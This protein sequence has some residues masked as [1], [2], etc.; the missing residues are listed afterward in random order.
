MSHDIDP[1]NK[2][3]FPSYVDHGSS[4][5][6][7]RSPFNDKGKGKERRRN[8]DDDSWVSTPDSIS[9]MES[10]D[11]FLEKLQEQHEQRKRE[12]EEADRVQ[13]IE[14]EEELR[15]ELE[16]TDR[17]AAE[18]ADRLAAEEAARLAEEEAIPRL[19]DCMACAGRLIS[20]FPV[21]ISP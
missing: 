14:L 1:A 7:I 15:R 13:A 3:I 12:Q 19:R 20:Q 4:Q 6:S 10:L 18:A 8:S 21:S 5:D 17:L 11:R 2:R 16:E 9:N